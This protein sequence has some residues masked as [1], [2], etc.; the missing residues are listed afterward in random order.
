MN[1]ESNFL[2]EL[3]RQ[4]QKRTTKKTKAK[5][6][7]IETPSKK[8]ENKKEDNYLFTLVIVAV[9]ILGVIGII[10]GYTK[11]KINKLN[12]GTDATK[13]LENQV[14][15]LQEQLTLMQEKAENLE[16]QNLS[17]KEVVLDLFEKNRSLPEK[18]NTLN[19]LDLTADA[20]N[21]TVKYPATW[22]PLISINTNK[23]ERIVSLQ[24]VGQVDFSN[25]ITI[26]NDY[27]DFAKLKIAE[28]EAIFAELDLIDR[29]DTD[30]G[31]IFYF[32]NLDKENNEVPTILVLTADNIYKAT[33]NISDKTK[34]NY[35][36]YR[37][38]FEE[39]LSTFTPVT[40]KKVIV[41]AKTEEKN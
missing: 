12:Q 15:S 23:Q 20:L 13:G 5:A 39:I 29:V 36:E 38:N 34:D 27:A 16:R 17:N 32:I 4:G 25:A 21:F 40:A 6:T 24:P 7:T 37:K 33:F 9:I 8:A 1:D 31:T 35:F 22:E 30:Y 10:F 14:A 41:P 2:E 26:K 28:K 11:D 3:E 18:T 19:W